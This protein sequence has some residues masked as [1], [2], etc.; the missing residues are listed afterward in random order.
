MSK[1]LIQIV[2]AATEKFGQ[3]DRISRRENTPHQ[4]LFI[5]L[6]R[7]KD[8][9]I[10]EASYMTIQGYCFAG[11]GGAQRVAFQHGHTELGARDNFNVRV[12]G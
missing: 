5:L 4:D 11:E 12:K 9:A 8:P 1:T 3:V 10:S 7:R 6:I 2:T